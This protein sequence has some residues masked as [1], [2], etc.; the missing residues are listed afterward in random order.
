VDAVRA[1]LVVNPKATTTTPAGRDVLTHA[2]A[3]ELKLEVLETR[4][5]GHAAEATADAV[6]DGVELVVAHGGDGTVNEVVNGLMVGAGASADGPRPPADDVPAVAVVPGGSANVFAR[7]LGVPRD[8]MAATSLILE[9]L[10]ARRSRTV[11]LGHAEDRW[12]TF[13]AGLGWD[14]DV[15]ARVEQA[16]AAGREASPLRYAATAFA[17]WTRELRTPSSMTVDVPGAE[18]VADVRMVFISNADIWTYLGSRAV[19]T[20]PGASFD[21]GLGVFGLREIGPITV[22][23]TIHEIL[24]PGGDPTG[25]NVL[26]EDAVPVV[27]V[28]SDEPLHLQ[29]DGDHLGQ[30]QEIEFRSVPEAL[31][32]VV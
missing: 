27:R 7:A 20:N 4:Y 14:A 31:R 11:G 15:V 12:F 2:L 13:N 18:P 32:V 5:R 30:R 9:A 24:K 16:R 3:S 6:R 29:M 1:L 19:R 21:D 28:T 8:P 22:A 23:R 25:R 26:R 17:Q 10:A